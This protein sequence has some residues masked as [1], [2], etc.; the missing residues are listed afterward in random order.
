MKHTTGWSFLFLSPFSAHAVRHRFFPRLAVFFLLVLFLAACG[1]L[2]RLAL[3][4]TTWS[5]AK[6]GIFQELK[7]NEALQKKV[8]FLGKLA[9]LEA[10]RLG[11]Y[12]EYDNA[13]R[14]KYGMNTISEDIRKAGVGGK[15]DMEEL[16]LA[17]L[18]DPAVAKA[19][20]IRQSLSSLIRQ[21]ELQ[22]A[23]FMRTA[24]Y[25]KQQHIQWG[26]RPSI[27]PVHGRIT[28]GYGNRVHPFLGYT[29]FHEGMDIAN[30]A[31]TPIFTTADGI[32]SFVGNQPL[33]GTM[34]TIDHGSNGIKTIYA[35]LM[36]A[37]VVP[38]Q[39]VRRYEL[40]GYMGNT[41]RVT[42][43]HLHYEVRVNNRPLDPMDYIMPGD[44]IVD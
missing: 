18:L 12:A 5:M 22:N 40:V 6:I 11:E 17:S 2:A 24:E 27:W 29:L 31:W 3:F 30:Q 26:R 41:G 19:D 37:S 32:V 35:H 42:G 21:A 14:L 39:V 34:V 25:V 28:S 4:A 7:T 10:R 16:I 43:T 9:V 20:S 23:T 1:G 38:G 15:P 44:F 36:Q 8:D 33:Y 13:L